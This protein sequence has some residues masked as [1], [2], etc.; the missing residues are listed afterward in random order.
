M[1]RNLRARR[2]RS[3]L[4]AFAVAVGI[5]TVV[6]IG[7][8][9][10]SLR[11]S[12]VSILKTGKADFIVA[13]RNASDILYSDL[14]PEKV[15]RVNAFPGVADAIGLLVATTKLPGAPLFLEIGVPADQLQR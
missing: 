13:Q 14:D 8:V 1:V 12:A 2:V 5:M 6:T 10:S 4:S 15:S 3:G 7:V 11:S 9:T